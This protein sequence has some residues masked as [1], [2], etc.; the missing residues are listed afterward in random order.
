MYR[1]FRTG[2]FIN[3]GMEE[4]N[5]DYQITPRDCATYALNQGGISMQEYMEWLQTDQSWESLLEVV[6]RLRKY[7]I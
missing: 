7:N 2:T 1:R 5:L 4:L 3:I 6:I